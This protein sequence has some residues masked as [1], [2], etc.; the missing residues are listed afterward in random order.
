MARAL[1]A[2]VLCLVAVDAVSQ[3]S[4]AASEYERLLLPFQTSVS[5]GNA[6]WQVAWWFRNES[7]TAVDVF[8]LAYSCGLPPPPTPD[9]P[10]VFVVPSPALPP[11][12][13][14]SCLAGD[15]LPSVPVPPS[16]PVVS[17]SPGAFLYV[18]ASRARDVIVAGS[19]R[20]ISRESSTGAAALTAIHQ[21]AFLRGSRSIMPIPAISGRRY[22]IRVYALPESLGAS[23]N[24]VVHVYEMQPKLAFSPHEEL[25]LTIPI[26]LEIPRSRVLPCLG[27]CDVPP[28]PFAPAVAEV[29]GSDWAGAMVQPS[30]LRVEISPESPDLRWWAVVSATDNVS[31]EISLYQPLPSGAQPR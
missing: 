26:R 12:T 1:L 19:V 30:T 3:P 22:A 15:V 28:V 9:G 24:V 11:R 10:R 23:A 27:V 2:A 25:R 16:I 14:V 29:L 18:E 6:A 8:P 13:T 7:E 5:A 20:W 31:N 21:D 17:S 4:R